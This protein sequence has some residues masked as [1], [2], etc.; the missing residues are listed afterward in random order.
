MIKKMNSFQVLDRTQNIHQNYLLEASA[1][2][3]KT[4]SIENIVVRLLIEGDPIGLDQILIV[5]FTNAATR[6]LKS[7]IH[8]NIVKSIH[9]LKE[10]QNCLQRG[11]SKKVDY[12][13]SIIEK[14]P[15]EI[16]RA[17]R[18][19]EQA[20]CGFDFSQ[21][22]TIHGFCARMLS[23][24]ALEANFNISLNDTDE[25]A[26][27]QLLRKAIRDLFRGG[28]L[29]KKF[30]NAELNLLLKQFKGD[31]EKMENELLKS[32]QRG[33][34][35]EPQPSLEKILDRFNNAMHALKTK[36]KLF[37]ANIM[38]DFL[39]RA[40]NY[41][42][43]NS[44]KQ[45]KPEILERVQKFAHLFD[46]DSWELEDLDLLISDQLFIVEIFDDSNKAKSK[47][48]NN[49]DV[50][51]P[52][53]TEHLKT[54]LQVFVNV[55][56][57]FSRLAYEFQILL[58]QYKEKDEF[59][60]H[61]DYL[62]SMCTALNDT[63]FRSNVQAKYKAAIIDEFQ[64]TD[65]AQ[66]E[67]FQKL[68][69]DKHSAKCLL[70][71]VGDPKQS[72][73]AFRQADIYT[74]L[75]AADQ[76]GSESRFSL[77]TNFRSQ[78]SLVKA[79]NKLFCESSCPGFLS[80]PKQD[81]SLNYP[82]VKSS[83][84]IASKQYSDN[85]GAVHFFVADEN[86]ESK[87]S[88]ELIERE[89]L[90]PFI[91]QEIQQ[92]SQKDHLLYNQFAILVS[93]HYQ[94]SRICD[95]LR[96]WNIPS[97]MQRAASL[98]NSP[99]APALKELL[100][101]ITNPKDQSALKIALGGKIIRWDHQEI[102]SLDDPQVLEK[103]L[104]K[105]Y[106]LRDELFEEGISSFFYK[107]LQTSW[108]EDSLTVYE[109][110]LREE[111]GE[112]FLEDLLQI[113]DLLLDYENTHRRGSEG[114]IQ[115][116]AQFKILTDSEGEKIKKIRDPS[117][118]AVQIMTIHASKGLEFDIVF[119]LGLAKRHKNNHLIIPIEKDNHRFLI[120]VDDKSMHE[121]QIHCREQDAEKLRQLYV[122]MTRA[123]YRL[124]NPVF[125]PASKIELGEA[126]PMDLFLA[127]L[128]HSP[129]KQSEDYERIRNFNLQSFKT[130]ID[131]LQHEASITYTLLNEAPP[132][133]ES[134]DMREEAA[135]CK[136]P[137]IAIPGKEIFIQSFS[138]LA[139]SL[140]GH[141]KNPLMDV[142]RDY[143][144]VVKTPHTLPAGTETGILLHKCFE[145]LDFEKYKNIE[146]PD[147]LLE[148]VD[149]LTFG[150]EY[151]K[152]SYVICEMIFNTLKVPLNEG[153]SLCN[154]SSQLC[155]KESEFFYQSFIKKSPGYLKGF[156]DLFFE[157]NGKYYLLDW[158]SNWL[159]PDCSHYH[160]DNLK[161]SM[162]ENSYFLQAQLYFEAIKKYIKLF[163]E[164]PFE[165]L[166][167]GIFYIY[168]RG[169]QKEETN[170]CGV[171]GFTFGSNGKEMRMQN[172]SQL[173]LLLHNPTLRKM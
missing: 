72:I 135:L 38:D 121:Y 90:F 171:Y 70:Y 142:P 120:P 16:Q 116:L 80:L 41:N 165:D 108:K 42:K 149:P 50:H 75:L 37:T 127:R 86:S 117:K 82:Y 8:E 13:S 5:T 98:A 159:G 111:D 167:G 74:Y 30:T 24:N 54:H 164:R 1:G 129:M 124:Y 150:T 89:F 29:D 160:R 69:L 154:V 107:F 170:H 140:G 67:I 71:L 15:E 33:I 100:A 21:I 68:F 43:I 97:T 3:G 91:V 105:F 92:L 65:P 119:T 139:S 63:N 147:N 109:R 23:E 7:R 103:V 22:F 172:Y 59:F 88:L 19:L 143:H 85:K 141:L 10:A 53:L 78:P 146:R 32:V 118:N 45:P 11:N 94:A 101:A 64:D 125:C 9:I 156:I 34:E 162:N 102:K 66:W 25:V 35:I 163:D 133:L 49:T 104:Y 81:S 39:K 61:D 166:F 40:P 62:K 28:S 20:L 58:K 18:N 144:A 4:F 51:Y 110:F 95:F 136:P 60:S 79:L 84:T 169:L 57:M 47:I 134:Y 99:A 76:I 158:K 148:L 77:D 128:G 83:P 27:T 73:Y 106:L 123:K 155:L 130:F 132:F 6:D 122:A 52:F 48:N 145:K 168:I 17:L 14:G 56:F 151:E 93:D 44:K 12:L 114:L 55:N 173:E 112:E 96:E 115:Y 31:L 2:T 46:K 131:S 161:A 153:F 137:R 152:W 157:H 87:R 113:S 138:T 36:H 126:S 26:S